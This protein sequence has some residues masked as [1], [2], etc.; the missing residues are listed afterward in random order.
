MH[1]HISFKI[2]KKNNLLT[3]SNY[4]R[5]QSECLLLHFSNIAI[6]LLHSHTE[7]NVATE[8]ISFSE[9]KPPHPQKKKSN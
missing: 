7:Q 4:N 8:F 5:E 1:Y 6:H 3:N 9:R 2:K